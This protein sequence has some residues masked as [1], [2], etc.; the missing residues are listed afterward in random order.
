MEFF[1]EDPSSIGQL[2]AI[3]SWARRFYRIPVREAALKQRNL[4]VEAGFNCLYAF[5]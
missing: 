1:T 2:P 4:L 5:S 3:G